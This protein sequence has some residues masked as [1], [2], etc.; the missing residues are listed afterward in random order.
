MGEL[1]IDEAS[2]QLTRDRRREG[3]VAAGAASRFAETE[4]SPSKVGTEYSMSLIS[5]ESLS[6]IVFFIIA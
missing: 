2:P 6:S 1:E 4:F 3:K 5:P